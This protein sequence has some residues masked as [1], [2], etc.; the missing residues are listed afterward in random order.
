VDPLTAAFRI[1]ALFP[2]DGASVLDEA[3][4]A[5]PWE[6]WLETVPP[7]YL[8]V[9]DLPAAEQGDRLLVQLREYLSQSGQLRAA[10]ALTRALVRRRVS[11]LGDEHPDTLAEVGALGA[12]ADRA[13]KTAEAS[14][15]LERAFQ[16]LRSVAGGRDLRLA[17]VASNYAWHHLRIQ[18][19]IKA[20]QCLE[21]ALRIRREAAPETTGP[22]AAQLAELLIRRGRVED[23]LPLLTEAWERYRDMYG[24]RDP[25]TV[26]RAQTL[27]SLLVAEGREAE[28]IPV[29]RVV[30]EAA[31]RSDDG[32]ARAQAAF[33]LGVALENAGKREEAMR[34]VEDALRWSRDHGSAAG[35]HP[36]LSTRLSQVSR[37]VLRRGRP[38]EAE[39]LLMEALEADRRTYGEASAEVAVRYANLGHLCAQLGRRPE[40]M[41]WLEP[42]ASLLRS[43]LG[44]EH[45]HTRFAVEELIRLWIEEG[46]D[47]VRR[48][49]Y[50]YAR[51]VLIRARDLARPVFGD[52]HWTI[53]EIRK[54]NLA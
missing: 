17:V 18:Q 27:A 21:Q 28:A 49:D 9:G 20:E 4:L 2:D 34:L 50:R 44:D 43:N 40:A 29:M 38:Q 11:A 32:E 1:A 16:G 6:A 45:P 48:R 42:A 47:G 26:A 10:V 53:A 19:P 51:D 52:K 13:G 12:L 39:G 3:E 30:L 37:M 33:Q 54:F 35:P 46:K 25:R 14:Q 24:V 5:G 31:T 36:E 22:V 8:D 7:V 15:L 23:A 41:G